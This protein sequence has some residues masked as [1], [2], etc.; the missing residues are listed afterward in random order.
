M[1][2]IQSIACVFLLVGCSTPQK[3]PSGSPTL[4]CMQYGTMRTAPMAPDA[5]KRLELACQRSMAK[6]KR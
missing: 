1:R 6:E 3:Q 5:M 4:A 2:N